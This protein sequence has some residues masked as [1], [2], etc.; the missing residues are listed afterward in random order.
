MGEVVRKR[1]WSTVR[2]TESGRTAEPVVVQRC[3]LDELGDQV[4]RAQNRVVHCQCELARAEQDLAEKQ[5]IFRDRVA[6]V[7]QELAIIKRL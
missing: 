3:S 2:V 6:E 5:D 7:F 1:W 4:R